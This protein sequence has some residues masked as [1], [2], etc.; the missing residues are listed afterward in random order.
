M[1]HAVTG[2]GNHLNPLSR[3]FVFVFL[4]FQLFN[5][6]SLKKIVAF[7]RLPLQ[8]PRNEIGSA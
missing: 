2:A 3:L 6:M 1:Y 8:Y 5:F 7:F 4:F